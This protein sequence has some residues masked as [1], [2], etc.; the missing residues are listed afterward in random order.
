[1]ISVL[2]VADVVTLLVL[3][4]NAVIVPIDVVGVDMMT[5]LEI[6]ISLVLEAGRRA[7]DVDDSNVLEVLGMI[8]LVEVVIGV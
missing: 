4:V 1:M 2:K 8:L 3:E 5:V 6:I 7:M